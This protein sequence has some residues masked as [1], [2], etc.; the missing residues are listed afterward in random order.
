MQ[1]HSLVSRH[2]GLKREPDLRIAFAYQLVFSASV[3]DLF[4]TVFADVCNVL[5][6]RARDLAD[7]LQPSEADY[8]TGRK[9]RT[10]HTL[11]EC[12]CNPPALG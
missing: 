10:L 12:K 11:A 9:L 4:P 5:T 6:K 1:V 2:E 3:H 8:R 7:H